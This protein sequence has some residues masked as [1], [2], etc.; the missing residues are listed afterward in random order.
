MLEESSQIVRETLQEEADTR[1]VKEELSFRLLE[2]VLL[3]VIDNEA[4]LVAHD[5]YR[6]HM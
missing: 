1:R 6:Y 4:H 5:T 2:R 3:E